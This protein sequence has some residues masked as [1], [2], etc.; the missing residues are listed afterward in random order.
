MKHERKKKWR[1]NER[2]RGEESELYK[3]WI[4]K[5]LT[6]DE[7]KGYAKINERKS[8]ENRWGWSKAKMA[9]DGEK[10]PKVT[11]EGKYFGNEVFQ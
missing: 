2:E 1:K 6:E 8:N 11:Y 9:K 3:N 10:E 7:S 5:K 4:K